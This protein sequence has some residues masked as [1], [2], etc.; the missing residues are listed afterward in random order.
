M[1]I[2]NFINGLV[3]TVIRGNRHSHK[4]S[5][6]DIIYFTF[7]ADRPHYTVDSIINS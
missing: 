3:V 4:L 7:V 2:P 1:Y 5:I 6:D